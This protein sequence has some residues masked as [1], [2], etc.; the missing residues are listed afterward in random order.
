MAKVRIAVRDLMG[1]VRKEEMGE[2]Q[3]VLVFEEK[4]NRGDTIHI[5]VEESNAFYVIRIDDALEESLVYLTRSYMFYTIP[6]GE[7]CI[8]YNPKA[9]T[10]DI[11]YLTIRRAEEHEIQ[12]YRNLEKNIMDQPDNQG[13]FP[14][15]FANV[16]TR[17][18]AVFAAR[19]AIDGL[20]AN[21]SHGK[22]PFG[23][24]GIN[25]QKDAE[26]TLAFGRCVDIDRIALYTRADFPHD[27]WWKQATISFS[28]GSSEVIQ[29]EKS[30]APH[31]FSIVRKN[32]TWLK[33]ENLIQSD[34]PSP[35]PALTQIAVYGTESSFSGRCGLR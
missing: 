23:S 9:F 22:W 27:N 16:E 17:G 34:D 8:S 15:A 21:T 18:E 10:G 19:N 30:A 32:I 7:K 28:D 6:F 26:F 35:F 5:Y 11:H 2:N 1:G 3:A 24:W 33:L 12:N 20:I 31:V 4:Y 13:C 14:H 25:M 29:M